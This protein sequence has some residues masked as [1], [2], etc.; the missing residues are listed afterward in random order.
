MEQYRLCLAPLRF[1]AG[2]KG[3]LIDAMI[4]QTPSIT[5]SIGSEGMYNNR[6]TDHPESW[7]GAI[8]DEPTGFAE[9]AVYLYSH[10]QP[11]VE[12]QNNGYALL[13]S[14]YDGHK[15]G[16]GLISAIKGVGENLDQHRLDNFTGGM[17]RHHTM[18]STQ[19]MSQW[20]AEKNT[21]KA[22]TENDS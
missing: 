1:G 12:A 22:L 13:E 9:E 18:K 16:T 6:S 5:T 17:L 7:P 3:K 8:A 21:N 4:A 15:L 2:I 19:Y 14:H 20:I 10:E 11:W